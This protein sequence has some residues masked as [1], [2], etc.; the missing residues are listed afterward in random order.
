M[1]GEFGW[2]SVPVRFRVSLVKTVSLNFFCVWQRLKKEVLGLRQFRG[3]PL[4]R[5]ARKATI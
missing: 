1:V 5:Q 4:G 2:N 3:Y